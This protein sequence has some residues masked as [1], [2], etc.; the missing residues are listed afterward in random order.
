MV[1]YKELSGFPGKKVPVSLKSYPKRFQLGERV[2]AIILEEIKKTPLDA[3]LFAGLCTD[4]IVKIVQNNYR[5]RR[6]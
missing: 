4:R 3:R 2:F 5:R 6:K 1:K